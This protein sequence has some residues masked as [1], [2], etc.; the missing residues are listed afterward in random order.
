[1]NNDFTI[2]VCYYSYYV[3]DIVQLFLVTY[4]HFVLYIHCESKKQGTTILSIT[5]PNVD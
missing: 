1:M 2:I 3:A 4:M 5:S